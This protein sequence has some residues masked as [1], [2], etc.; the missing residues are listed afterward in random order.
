MGR[1]AWK[2]TALGQKARRHH[3]TEEGGLPAPERQETSALESKR[4]TIAKRSHRMEEK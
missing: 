3:Q 4:T 1:V 2:K